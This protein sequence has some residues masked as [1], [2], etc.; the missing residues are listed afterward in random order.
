MSNRQLGQA[1]STALVDDAG[2]RLYQIYRQRRGKLPF[3]EIRFV[4]IAGDNLEHEMLSYSVWCSSTPIPKYFDNNLQPRNPNHEGPTKLLV[5]TTLAKYMGKVLVQ[6]RRKF[7]AHPDFVGLREKEVPGWWSRM[8]AAFEKECDSFHLTIGSEF[9]FGETTTRPLYSDN[10]HVGYQ[11]SDLPLNDFISVIDLRSI[12]HHL[13][14]TATLGHTTEG[15]LQQRAWIAILYLAAGRGG[16]IKFIDTADWMYH[17]LYQVTDTG[18]TE[19]KTRSKYAMPMV[20]HKCH[21]LFDFYHAIGSFWAVESG[22]FRATDDQRAIQ[23]YLFPDLHSISDPNVT[24]KITSLIRENLPE[25]CPKDIE[26]TFTAKSLR[27]GS[28]TELMTHRSLTGLDVCGRSGHATGTTLDTY[29]DKTFIVRGLRG[30]R[31]LAHFGD[32]DANIKVPTLECL[33]AH[34]ANAVEALL[35]KL[36]VVSVPAFMPTG[37]L[38]IVLRTCAASLI[39][40]HQMVQ[41]EFTPA[42]SVA[43]SL[44]NAAR[45]AGISDARYAGEP[46]ECILDKWSEIILKDFRAQNPEIAEATPDMAKMAEVMNQQTRLL[47]DMR[48]DIRE[49]RSDRDKS[50]QHAVTQQQRISFLETSHA[51]LGQQLKQAHGKLEMLKTPPA[52]ASSSVRKRSLQDDI[53]GENNVGNGGSAGSNKSPRST[54][55]EAA[56]VPPDT[57]QPMIPDTQQPMIAPQALVYGAEARANAEKGSNKGIVISMV[58]NDLYQQNRL[59]GVAWKDATLPA[60]Y[61]EKQQLRNALELCEAVTSEEESKALKSDGLSNMDLMIHTKSIEAKCFMKMW[62]YEGFDADL[63]AKMNT[64]KNKSQQKKPTY[65][66]LGK[67]VRLYK[68]YLAAA[69]GNTGDYND[70]KLRSRPK[71]PDPGT[72]DGNHSMRN[73][74]G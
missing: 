53:D 31:A 70:E 9:T 4:E 54:M 57:Q 18:W 71:M 10:G 25:G 27:K 62:E 19:L 65:L 40:H 13:M 69:S 32:V 51:S 1:R 68:K 64:K 47:I 72:P 66:A 7:P 43:S 12:L 46:P 37:S 39:M 3:D 50:N 24:K 6:I 49:L 2:L 22:L 28:I 41:S 73:F 16:E 45:A 59:K 34:A 29:A 5:T 56:A 55:Q 23:S 33:G 63:E 52:A 58:L 60:K 11:Q 67:R 15:K 35:D 61:S 44:R 74:L 48:T 8:R 36:F 17:P 26:D 42:N 38:H 20:P 14:K 21:F 30:A